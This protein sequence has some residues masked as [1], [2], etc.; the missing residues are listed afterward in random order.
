MT[1]KSFLSFVLSGLAVLL[2]TTAVAAQP[3]AQKT[4]AYID[5][6]WTTLTRSMDDC[7]ALGDSK[8]GTRP[9]LYLPANLPMPPDLSEQNFEDAIEDYLAGEPAMPA[10]AG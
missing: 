4:R 3:D 2:A 10:C 8:V 6:A 1:M 9:L 5:R 7:S